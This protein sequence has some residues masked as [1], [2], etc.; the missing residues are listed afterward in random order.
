MPGTLKKVSSYSHSSVF[1][2]STR[3][4]TLAAEDAP[5]DMFLPH[6]AL[7]DLAPLLFICCDM[8][9]DCCYTVSKLQAK[10][11]ELIMHSST[12]G[13]AWGKPELG[14]LEGCRAQL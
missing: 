2:N 5:W 8:K 11:A 4:F 9:F 13:A 1:Q 6:K 3:I 10:T 14:L 7:Q 12:I